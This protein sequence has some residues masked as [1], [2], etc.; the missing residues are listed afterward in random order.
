MGKFKTEKQCQ[1]SERINEINFMQK[2]TD[3]GINIMNLYYQNG[4]LIKLKT[5]SSIDNKLTI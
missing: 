5:G 1:N 3:T 2:N 4:K